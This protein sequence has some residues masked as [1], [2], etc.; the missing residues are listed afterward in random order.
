MAL[1]GLLAALDRRYRVAERKRERPETSQ[2]EPKGQRR[3]RASRPA[4]PQGERG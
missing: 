3:R 4:V 2:P 1:G